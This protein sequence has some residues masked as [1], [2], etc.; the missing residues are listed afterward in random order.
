[1][2]SLSIIFDYDELSSSGNPLNF[3]FER[4]IVFHGKYKPHI[5]TITHNHI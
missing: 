3:I 4:R 5:Y 1:M 2:I